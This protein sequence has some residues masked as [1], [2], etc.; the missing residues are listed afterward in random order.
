MVSDKNPEQMAQL[1][2][3]ITLR[4]PKASVILRRVRVK[5]NIEVNIKPTIQE[6]A[7]AFCE[8][9]ADG[10]AV[11]FDLV[12]K[13]SGKWDESLSVQMQ[14]VSGSGCKNAR[15]TRVMKKIGEYA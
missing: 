9:E 3:N 12:G 8:L 10:M 13:Y 15:A 6:L 4:Q 5:R 7:E 11:F 2:R 1:A 14:F